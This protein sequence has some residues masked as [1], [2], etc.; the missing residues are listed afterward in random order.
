M[1]E[2]FQH[3]EDSA[4]TFRIVVNSG[5]SYADLLYKCSPEYFN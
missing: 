4:R 2:A 1:E 3:S 5:T